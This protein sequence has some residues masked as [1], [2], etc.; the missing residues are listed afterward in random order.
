MPNAEMFW[1]QIGAYNEAT[2]PLQII[3]VIGALALTYLVFTRPG[4]RTDVVVKAFLAFAFAWN[5]VVYFLFFAR[6]PFSIFTGVPL[7][8]IVA[9]LFA[10]DMFTKRTQFRLP[11]APWRKALTIFW[12]LLAFLYPLIGWALG[13]PYPT[14]CTPMMPC[15]LTV[16][17][18]ALVAAAAPNADRKAFVFLL[19]WAFLGL[20]KCLGALDCQEDCILFAAGV[21]A[22]IVLIKYWRARAPEGEVSLPVSP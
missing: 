15:P 20:P 12:I 3:L 11:D 5:G 10:V 13:H 8:L 22:L 6:T 14:T 1:T 18:L 2:F 21:H 16:F 9:V 4:T 7:F 17:A 19:P